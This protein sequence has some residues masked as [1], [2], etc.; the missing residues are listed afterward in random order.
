MS[1]IRILFVFVLALDVSTASSQ[2]GTVSFGIQYRPLIPNVAFDGDPVQMSNDSVSAEVTT[3]IGHSF[4][5]LIRTNFTDRW[6]LE[7]GINQT[8]RNYLL[9][10][11]SVEDPV[12]EKFTLSMVTYELPVQMLYYVRFTDKLY[13]NALAGGSFNFYPTE[14]ISN[15]PDLQFRASSARREWIGI[16]L[17]SNVG[18]EYRTYNSGYFYLGASLHR[19][20]KSIAEMRVIYRPYLASS[21]VAYNFISGNFLTLDFRYF[22]PA[23]KKS[24]NEKTEEPVRGR[25]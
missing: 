22:F 8:R 21:P 14:H 5:F 6:S 4:G 7:T 19:P 10:A 11:H 13:M 3:K 24:V 20:L 1:W 12:S 15:S 2:K 18:F 17:L 23:E 9:D 25:R 16:S